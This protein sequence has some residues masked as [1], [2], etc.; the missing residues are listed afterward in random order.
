MFPITGKLKPGQKKTILF[1]FSPAL[2]KLYQRKFLIKIDDNHEKCII[3]VR[4]QGTSVNLNLNQDKF[5]IPPSLPYDDLAYIELEIQN[6]S[7][8]DT[9]LYSLD[10]DKQFVWENN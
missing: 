8:Y 9:E 3:I 1:T 6:P 2:D 7:D 5:E 4:G 10:Y